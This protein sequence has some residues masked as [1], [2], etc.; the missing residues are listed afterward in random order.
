MAFED[1]KKSRGAGVSTSSP[2]TVP[3]GTPTSVSGGF[4]SWKKKKKAGLLEPID[5]ESIV[6]PSQST[7]EQVKPEDQVAE[8]TKTWEQKSFLEKTKDTLGEVPETI[9]TH[10]KK[11]GEALGFDEFVKPAK[12][13]VAQ[14]KPVDQ[15]EHDQKPTFGDRV[16]GTGLSVV[17]GTIGVVKTVPDV[18]RFGANLASG[19]KYEQTK[20]GQGNRWASQQMQEA[21]DIAQSIKP[22]SIQ[23]LEANQVISRDESGKWQINAPNPTQAINVI[24]E[25][26]PQIPGY[27][28]GGKWIGAAGAGLMRVP[29]AAKLLSKIPGAEKAVATISKY[30]EPVQQGAVNAP[31]I[32]S[33]TFSSTYDEVFQQAKS[34]GMSD[35]EAQKIATEQALQAGKEIAPVSAVTGAGLGF[36]QRSTGGLITRTGKGIIKEGVS[37]APEETWQQSAQNRAAKRLDPSREIVSPEAL[38]AGA[39][40]FIAGGAT[41]GVVAATNKVEIPNGYNPKKK[42]R[43]ILRS[44]QFR[45]TGESSSY[46]R[47]NEYERIT[48]NR[49]NF[50]VNQRK[51]LWRTSFFRNNDKIGRLFGTDHRPYT[52]KTDEHRN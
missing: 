52:G 3:T 4:D 32:A 16:L 30:A 42:R 34:Q 21:L 45:R 38:N 23:E 43:E 44:N 28:V 33:Q 27:L 11:T 5:Y 15:I 29:G 49:E 31:I 48:R 40:G 26:L 12:T 7:H 41:G 10:L 17:K 19:G 51:K 2:S 47:K 9:G 24:A 35:E 1:W 20:I 36:A 6:K 8:E 50:G 14:P 13:P 37:E 22:E 25:S 39:M 46:Y 18:L